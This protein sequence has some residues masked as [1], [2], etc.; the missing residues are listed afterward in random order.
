MLR[1]AVPLV[2]L[3]TF[4]GCLGGGEPEAPAAAAPAADKASA[5]TVAANATF[6]MEPDA[7]NG[8]VVPVATPIAYSG[9]TP[10][11]V[12]QFIAGQCLDAQPGTED[13]HML[14]PVEGQGKLLA[15]QVTYGE[16]APGMDFYVGVC[17]GPDEGTQCT[18]Y[19]TG[20]S[21]LVVEFDLSSYPPGTP[22]GISV[23]SLNTAAMETATM[24]FAPVDFEVAGTL[25]S[26]PATA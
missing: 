7:A 16:Q 14:D 11:S 1:L 18:E 13:F 25:T 26:L 20:P 22:F 8:T 12:C 23:G 10:A 2:L 3:A 15:L 9:R 21:P 17:F 19:Q 24:V 5:E 4:A 6:A